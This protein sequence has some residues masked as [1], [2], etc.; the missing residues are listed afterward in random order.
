MI[1][2][3][4]VHFFCIGDAVQDQFV[5]GDVQN[6]SQEAL[7]PVFCWRGERAML[8]GVGDVVADLRTL[9]PLAT[10]IA[11][12]GRDAE[13]AV[14]SGLL[15]RAGARAFLLESERVRRF[16]RCGLLRSAIMFSRLIGTARSDDYQRP[17]LVDYAKKLQIWASCACSPGLREA[18]FQGGI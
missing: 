18:G 1:D 10:L 3:S 16:R 17:V 7:V 9:G 14:V 11:R 2:F 12:I 4:R 8:G 13:G 5:S 15:E 6:I